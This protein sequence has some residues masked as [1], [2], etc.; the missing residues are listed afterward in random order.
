VFNGAGNVS[1]NSS[2]GFTSLQFNGIQTVGSG[3]SDAL[4]GQGLFA[5]LNA[6]ANTVA[7]INVPI[8]APAGT[9]VVVNRDGAGTGTV[10]LNA[11]NNFQSIRVDAGT[12]EVSDSSQLYPTSGGELDGGM[13]LIGNEEA[14]GRTATLQ[15]AGSSAFVSP[16]DVT[17]QLNSQASTIDVTNPNGATIQG[18]IL[19]GGNLVKTGPDTLTLQSEVDTLKEPMPGNEYLGATIVNQG[20]LALDSH[21]ASTSDPIYSINGAGGLIINNGG[22]VQIERYGQIN[23]QWVP[24]TVN[25][26]GTLD[27]G[28]F[29]TAVKDLT[30]N[31][32]LIQGQGGDVL[33]ATSLSGTGGQIDL[34]NAS[35][36]I[37]NLYGSATNTFAGAITG[38]AGTLALQTPGSTLVLTGTNGFQG[39]TSIAGGTLEVDG[40][41]G[42]EFVTV[43]P[44]GPGAANLA[45]VGTVAG[46][47]N[48][49]YGGVVSPGK[50]S[51]ATGILNVGND[52]TFS[53]GSTF[54]TLVNGPTVGTG[55]DQLNVQ[56]TVSLGGAT[57]ALGGTGFR[58]TRTT[59]PLVLISSTAP[60][61]GT[62]AGLPEGAKVTI[63]AFHG[64][65]SYK[66]DEVVLIPAPTVTL[67]PRSQTVTVGQT[68]IFRSSA[69]GSM[70]L[71]VQWYVQTTP[72]GP[73]VPVQN[74]VI[75][76][77]GG[78]SVSG[79]TTP[80]LRISN[81]QTAESG[82]VF[83]ATYS[84]TVSGQ[85]ESTDTSS[86]T[87]T[88]L[89]I[90]RGHHWGF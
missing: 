89:K 90:Q 59:Q 11:A 79:A 43:G 36:D 81:A 32:G 68:A 49:Q 10:V 13:V 48:V 73:F 69:V 6:A 57:L 28:T 65:I 1:L 54:H 18:R 39:T 83:R 34:T 74:A 29:T 24:A 9:Y 8:N 44:S 15:L 75:P 58:M 22:T 56:G 35:L 5:S 53:S 46:F 3:S 64:T 77:G 41:L 4:T 76:G 47:V 30:V 16:L 7:T 25:T 52:V 14:P 66:N 80:T 50:T 87:L 17:Y 55:Y 20:T 86:V 67:Q 38:I 84:D 19:G 63:G 26:G 45:G 85:T 21:L 60:I 12:L 71:T 78:A 72:N 62:F 37:T 51:G 70:P 40:S 61:S 88:V 82:W 33:N 42:S 27:L 2:L 23:P 31:G